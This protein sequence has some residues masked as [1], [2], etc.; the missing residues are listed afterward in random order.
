MIKILFILVLVSITTLASA[1]TRPLENYFASV[2]P[3]NKVKAT[4]D[5]MRSSTKSRSQCYNR[6]Y[7]WSYE[8][9]KINKVH[10]KK[11]LIYYTNK[12]RKLLNPDWGFHI[13]P[14]VTVDPS[15]KVSSIPYPLE[16]SSTS[17]DLIGK[18]FGIEGQANKEREVLSLGGQELNMV[19][20]REF[21]SGPTTVSEWVDFFIKR[22][23]QKL[24]VMRSELLTEI[25]ALESELSSLGR[26]TRQ[27]RL[28]S[29]KSK[30]AKAEEKL[31][32][33]G[34]SKTQKAD[35]SCEMIEHVSSFDEANAQG[36]D[37]KDWCY[38]Q[39]I[40]Q[41]YWNPVDLRNLNYENQA[42][43][44]FNK[45]FLT[46]AKKEAFTDW[47][48]IGLDLKSGNS[49]LQKEMDRIDASFDHELFLMNESFNKQMLSLESSSDKQALE[50]KHLK[51]VEALE[52]NRSI[53]LSQVQE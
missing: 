39:L 19:M 51:Q 21:T 17:T 12:Y 42:I 8:L 26:L 11:I 37:A 44:S 36:E 52:L 1:A 15:N 40:S 16:T 2:I 5:S 22:G 47:R 20:D 24:E 45:G 50:L 43:T 18:R 32:I 53:S 35:I 33:L 23:E 14:V 31:K 4:F 10:S 38:V 28:E 7:V 13:S 46:A 49:G 41:Y 48:T 3:S 29:V 30:L 9:A 25:N 6:A 27:G 34:L